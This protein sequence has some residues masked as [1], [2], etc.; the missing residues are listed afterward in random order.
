[1]RT[2]PSL[3]LLTLFLRGRLDPSAMDDIRAHLATNCRK[4]EAEMRWAKTVLDAARNDPA[5]TP[6]E[7]ILAAGRRIF[8][9]YERRRSERNPRIL[10]ALLM[11]DSVWIP[12]P[13]G[14]RAP[15]SGQRRLLFSA[16]PYEIDLEISRIRRGAFDLLGQ[17]SPTD[18]LRASEMVTLQRQGRRTTTVDERGLF[19]FDAVA[20]GLATLTINLG[21]KAIRLAHVRIG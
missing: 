2:E 6:P 17:L 12:I 19:A 5:E 3:E 7:S 1:M 8:A 20:P 9:D 14:A 21:D 18:R 13:A 11:F 15:A 10:H 4:C 16:E